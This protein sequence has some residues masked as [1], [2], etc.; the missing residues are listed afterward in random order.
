[1]PIKHQDYSYRNRQGLRY[2]CWGDFPT[3]GS[4]DTQRENFK[5]N[6]LK[7]FTENHKDYYRVFVQELK[8]KELGII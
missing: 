3:K 5:G 2:V 8:A 1:M 6:G 4:A 7:S